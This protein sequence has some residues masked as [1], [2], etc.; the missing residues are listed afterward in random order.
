[1][2]RLEYGV[3]VPIPILDDPC[4]ILVTF[5]PLDISRLR[6]ENSIQSLELHFLNTLEVISG[7]LAPRIDRA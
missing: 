7:P 3:I 6:I 4:G 2:Q 1:M 5:L